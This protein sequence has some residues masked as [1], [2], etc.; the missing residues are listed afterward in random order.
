MKRY[1]I[2]G[3]LAATSMFGVSHAVADSYGNS[4][5]NCKD[6]IAAQMDVHRDDVRMKVRNIKTR[7]TGRDLRFH[8]YANS[9]EAN[10]RD[11]VIANCKVHRKGEILAVEF[12]NGSYPVAGSVPVNKSDS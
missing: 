2:A 6:A 5:S 7:S 1:I 12:I 10:L 11:K 9:P 8:I 3:S 4:V